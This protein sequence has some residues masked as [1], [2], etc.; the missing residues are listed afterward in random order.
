MAQKRL[1]NQA[2][3]CGAFLEA[4]ATDRITFTIESLERLETEI[5]DRTAPKIR[6]PKAIQS[7]LK[8]TEANGDC[9]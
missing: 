3:A 9:C 2:I 6:L 4:G 7:I 5:L 1:L 8:I